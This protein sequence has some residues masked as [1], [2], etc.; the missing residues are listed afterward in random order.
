MNRDCKTE[1]YCAGDW[2]GISRID[3]FAI[4]WLLLPLTLFLLGWV[5]NA[6][7]IPILVLLFYSLWEL[8][9]TRRRDAITFFLDRNFLCSVLLFGIILFFAGL[10]G[11]WEQHT[12]Y[13]VRN[14]IFY[15]LVSKDWPTPL[16][17]GKY[18]IY[19]FQSWL[20]AALFG[21]M[22]GWSAANYAF[23]LWNLV[24]SA[25]L[26]HYVFKAVQSDSF[27]YI[28]LFV[29]FGGVEYGPDI[30]YAHYVDGVSWSDAR[31]LSYMLMDPFV[32]FSPIISCRSIVHCFLPLALVCGMSFQTR[33]IRQIPLF[34]LAA[35]FAYS[36]MGGV[37]YALV[38]MFLWMK[39]NGWVKTFPSFS[40]VAGVLVCLVRYKINIAMLGVLVLMLFYYG[41]GHEASGYEWGRLWNASYIVKLSFFLFFNFIVCS[42]I[43]W[44][45]TRDCFVWYLFG[46]HVL[47]MVSSMIMHHDMAMK[48]SAVINFYMYILFCRAFR[49]ASGTRWYYYAYMFL[50]C[51]YLSVFTGGLT[52]VIIS[53]TIYVLMGLRWRTAV[54]LFILMITGCVLSMYALPRKRTEVMEKLRG[55]RVC[56]HANIGIY[57]ADG[58]SGK[59]W[60]YKTF[61]Q[62]QRMPFVF[63]RPD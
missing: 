3:L 61:P 57:Q 59:W 45:E 6:I 7:S 9:R 1:L 49:K 26:I 22:G 55:E 8:H 37:F 27:I 28:V 32:M 54:S 10:T 44:R 40:P 2:E 42:V 12:D 13:G 25:L 50:S 34:L 62:A 18:F 53:G 24:G 35:A 36:P 20:P 16:A 15:D 4:I 30:L 31:I 48:G 33:L 19:Y 38:L 11:N 17:D 29:G 43:V 63:K 39:S 51:G 46:V 60:W 58:G 21:K 14:D 41:S 56:Y 47:C 52:A 5:I 23:Y